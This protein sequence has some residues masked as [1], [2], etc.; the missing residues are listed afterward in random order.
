[1]TRIEFDAHQH[2]RWAR[3]DAWRYI[4]EVVE[5]GKPPTQPGIGEGEGGPV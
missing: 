1:M 4:R 2:E 3:P 5:A